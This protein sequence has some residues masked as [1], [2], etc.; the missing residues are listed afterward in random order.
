MSRLLQ[1]LKNLEARPSQPPTGKGLLAHLA[2]KYH[3][4][5]PDP[6]KTPSNAGKPSPILPRP[7]ASPLDC[8]SAGVPTILLNLPTGEAS[9]PSDS[10]A[11][12][13]VNEM[14][15]P[16]ALLP[17]LPPLPSAAPVA[18]LDP[19]QAE[20]DRGSGPPAE[21]PDNFSESPAPEL[22]SGIED[23]PQP[24]VR[25]PTLLERSV[26]RT[27][28]DPL[29]AEPLR[30]LADRLRTDLDQVAG[31]SVLLSGVG[32]ASETHEVLVL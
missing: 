24:A 9:V 8:L 19:P 11:P 12:V 18:P 20:V 28:T 14:L 15:P 13:I 27:L 29:R 31:R 25:Q 3:P 2:D 23:P 16:P 4:P 7:L 30:Q 21:A 1:A 10:F 6:P 32:P 26:R 17:L 5:S 22:Q